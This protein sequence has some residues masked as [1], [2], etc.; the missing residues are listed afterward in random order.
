MN[1]ERRR[2]RP[3]QSREVLLLGQHLEGSQS[4]GQRCPSIPD[5]FG[6]DQP[7]GRVAGESLGIVEVF[8]ACQAA[9]DGLPQQVGEEELRTL[10][11]AQV[12]QML[13]EQISEPESLVKFAHEDQAAV[14]GDART[15]EIKC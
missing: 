15:L 4:G 3:C 11:T 2:S 7:E 8:V 5:L 14:E 9:V 12:R 1:R 13:L 6:A 10:L